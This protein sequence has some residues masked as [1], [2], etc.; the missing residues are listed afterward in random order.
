MIIIVYR[1]IAWISIDPPF[2]TQAAVLDSI[3]VN[4]LIDAFTQAVTQA[5]GDTK[6]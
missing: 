5:R 1:E 6:P 4:G 2:T 3:R